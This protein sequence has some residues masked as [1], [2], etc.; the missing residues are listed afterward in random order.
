MKNCFFGILLL[1]TMF[2]SGKAA[3][4]ERF[5][6]RAGAGFPELLNLGLRIQFDQS[7]LGLAVG[8]FPEPDEDIFTLTGNY[9]YHFGGS[10]KYTSLRPWFLTAG[11]TFLSDETE[12]ERQE[13]FLLAPKVGR[14]F[15]ISPKFGIALEAGLLVILSEDETVKKERERGWLDIFNHDF[16][17]SIFPSAGVN[18]FY[19]F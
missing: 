5:S 13:V 16:K 14:E 19:R 8:T 9:Y 6:V 15:N 17:E 11:L 4:Q 7:E 10:S 18:L 1:W 2:L 3:A 12:W